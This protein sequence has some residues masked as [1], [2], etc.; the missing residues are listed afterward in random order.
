[1]SF[2]VPSLLD[3]GGDS[4]TATQASSPQS[5][6]PTEVSSPR[7]S[8]RP[9][10]RRHLP[11]VSRQRFRDLEPRRERER[12]MLLNSPVAHGFFHLNALH[13]PHPS[14]NLHALPRHP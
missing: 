1:A 13:P 10:K 8:V 2:H 11:L 14:Q 5:S 4:L 6:S 7:S 3:Q 12:D 9:D